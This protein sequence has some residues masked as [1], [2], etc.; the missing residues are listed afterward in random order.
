MMEERK[1]NQNR[2]EQQEIL[3][4]NVVE[5]KRLENPG[6]YDTNMEKKLEK[7]RNAITFGID[8]TEEYEGNNREK[9]Q[10]SQ[11]KIGDGDDNTLEENEIEAMLDSMGITS[12]EGEQ[13]HTREKLEKRDRLRWEL[14]PDSAEDYLERLE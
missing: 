9:T 12:A 10:M 5:I 6:K 11:E 7:L 1:N 4:T 3:L 2:Q 8:I 14:E 13:V